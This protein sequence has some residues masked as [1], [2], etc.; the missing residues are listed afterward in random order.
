[1]TYNNENERRCNFRRKTDRFIEYEFSRGIRSLMM[2][3]LDF[4]EDE[5]K[6]AELEL[7]LVDM[8]FLNNE[9][10][11]QLKYAKEEIKQL[12]MKLEYAN[13]EIDQLKHYS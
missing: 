11:L 9:L 4:K 10:L 12:A 3:I 2:D 8:V 1:M 6:I 5:G 13:Y 7:K